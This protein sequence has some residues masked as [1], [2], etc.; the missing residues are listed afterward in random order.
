VALNLFRLFYSA[1]FQLA[2][3]LYTFFSKARQ[4]LALLYSTESR[5]FDS[6]LFLQRWPNLLHL[7]DMLSLALMEVPMAMLPSIGLSAT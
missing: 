2:P 6:S 3:G 7:L 4:S 5:I 1:V